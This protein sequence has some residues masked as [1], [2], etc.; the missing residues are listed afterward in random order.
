MLTNKTVINNAK[1]LFEKDFWKA[2]S[3]SFNNAIDFLGAWQPVVH[4]Y[5]I[6][7]SCECIF[8]KRSLPYKIFYVI[9]VH[10]R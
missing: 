9:N 4:F 8:A 7:K 2:T 5:S 1:Y 6:E 10:H 3:K